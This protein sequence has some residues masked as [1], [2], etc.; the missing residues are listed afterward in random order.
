M[1]TTIKFFAAVSFFAFL[2]SCQQ[3]DIQPENYAVYAGSS[4]TG[5][6]AKPSAHR[7]NAE[8]LKEMETG[9]EVTGPVRSNNTGTSINK[10]SAVKK[11]ALL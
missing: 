10:G 11:K 1:K 6:K 3:E 8:D 7:L 9:S 5:E 4:V 2:T